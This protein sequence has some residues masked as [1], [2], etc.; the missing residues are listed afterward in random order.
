MLLLALSPTYYFLTISLPYHFLFLLP[1]LPCIK[2][3]RR[4]RVVAIAHPLPLIPYPISEKKTPSMAPNDAA[5]HST[6]RVHPLESSINDHQGREH[7]HGRD[8]TRVKSKTNNEMKQRADQ[9]KSNQ[10]RF[11]IPFRPPLFSAPSP[12]PLRVSFPASRTL[13]K[14]E[15]KPRF[16]RHR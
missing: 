9:I 15:I 2:V 7:E 11:N 13:G 8:K 5:A 14:G 16:V 6:P 10:T 12:S 1:H 3:H 4:C